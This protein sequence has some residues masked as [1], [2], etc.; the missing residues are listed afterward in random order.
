MQIL[1][2]PFGDY[3]TNCYIVK[4]EYGDLIIDPGIGAY[5]WCIKNIQNPLAIL[6]THGHFDHVSDVSKIRNELK[7]PVYIHKLDE[8]MLKSGNQFGFKFEGCSADF[9]IDEGVFNINGLEAKYMHF[10]GHTPGCSM[11]M[12]K[13]TIFS[14]DFIFCDSIG[15]WDFEFSNAKDMLKSLQ[16]A[17]LIQGDYTIYPGHGIQTTLKAEIKRLPL[18]IEYVKRDIKD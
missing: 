15:R 9:A 6:C 5:Q 10:P 1:S 7:I 3:Q 11:I 16:K 18:W 2:Q 8:F 12:I 4:T 13:N 17:T 14:G